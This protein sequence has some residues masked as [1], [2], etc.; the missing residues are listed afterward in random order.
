M[1]YRHAFHAG[2]FA[3]VVKHVG[4]VCLLRRLI[5]KPKP[6]S[7]VET[8]AGRGVY[9]LRGGAALRTREAA[10][11]IQRVA[12]AGVTTGPVGDYLAI[13]R[14]MNPSGTVATYPG[15]PVIAAALLRPGDRAILCERQPDEASALEERFRADSRISVRRGDGY[16]ALN[17]I[18]PPAPRRGCVLIDPPYESPDDI[19]KALGAMERGLKR[20]PTGVFALWYPIKERRDA[21]ALRRRLRVAGEEVVALEF[22]VTP[23]DNPARLNG[24]GLAIVRPPWQLASALAA[25]CTQLA[26]VLSGGRPARA[27]V[28]QVGGGNDGTADGG[29]RGHHRRACRRSA[30]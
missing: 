10:D 4:L 3:D 15:S 23:D 25:A 24:A 5:E 8:H 26:A 1:N 29:S 6:L 13:V 16:A 30:G 2:N 22:C 12:G 27:E 14:G 21:V 18:L 28:I 9:D 11:G 7:Y 19:D 20:W 17:G